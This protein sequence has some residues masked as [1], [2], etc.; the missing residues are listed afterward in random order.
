M[1]KILYVVE[2]F[3]GGIYT[4]LKELTNVVKK[5][6]EVVIAYGEREETPNIEI[7]EKDFK[8]VKLMKVNNFTREINLIKDFN[9]LFELK[10]II[11]NERPDIIHLNS[12]KAGVLGRLASNGRKY[13]M[14]YN[15][16]G[17]SFLKSDDSKIKRRIY[18]FIEKIMAL[19]NNKCVIVGC[20]RRRI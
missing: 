17:F 6:Y 12:S 2:S 4:F 19:I 20:S 18:W 10:K 5:K 15:P 9:A 11:K 7:L 13:T 8:G 3:G 1:K 16:H 14:L